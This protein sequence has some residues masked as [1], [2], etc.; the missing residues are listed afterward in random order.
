[1]RTTTELCLIIGFSTVVC[2]CGPSAYSLL[3]VEEN[4]PSCRELL[5]DGKTRP[6]RTTLYETKVGD[7]PPAM[8]AIHETGCL[9]AN[10]TVVLIHGCASSSETWRFLVGD[11]GADHRLVLVDLL[12]CGRSEC[13][14]PTSLGPR[15]YSPDAMAHRVS[16]ALGASLANQPTQPQVTLVGHSLGALIALRM[17]G[18]HELRRRYDDVVGC[19]DRMVLLTPLDVELANPPA[20][21]FELAM[22]SPLAVRIADVTGILRERVAQG[23]RLSVCNPK[24]ALRGG[25]DR[26]C[27]T[28][29]SR[30][31]LLA[32]QAILKQAVPNDGERLDWTTIESI[33]AD[34]ANVNVPCLIVWGR[35]DETLPLAMGYKLAAEIPTAQLHIVDGCKHSV[36]LERPVL[37][38]DFI[39]QFPWSN[40]RHVQ[41]TSR[42]LKFSRSFD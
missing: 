15:G 11:L 12:G 8:I 7:E 6:W 3:A 35:Y 9:S 20:I 42:V 29:T 33:V 5:D 39:R 21:L 26:L 13:P 40:D 2:G 32:L 27:A 17:M 22:I 14:N 4:V 19:V 23:T 10:R 36:H 28:L 31:K 38:A 25:V 34:Y 30:T 16:Q 24:R 37:A 41:R 1:M 18:N